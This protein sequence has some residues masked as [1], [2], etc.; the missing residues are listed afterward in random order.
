MSERVEALVER[1]LLIWARKSAHLTVQ[2]AA[3]KVRVKEKRLQSWEDGE[4]RPTISSSETWETFIRDQSPFFIFPS[5]Q[6]ILLRY[7][8]SVDLLIRKPAF[9]RQ[10]CN[11]KRG[12]HKREGILH[13]SYITIWI[14]KY[15][16]HLL[17]Y[18]Y[19]MSQ[20]LWH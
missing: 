17:K 12:V 15:P 3:N 10:N 4:T 8:T 19:Q 16:N 11:L 7:E 13:S 20:K 5:R 14:M 6:K 9:Y 1:E 18:V 2:R